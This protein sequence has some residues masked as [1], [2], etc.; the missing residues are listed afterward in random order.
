[1]PPFLLNVAAVLAVPIALL[2]DRAYPSIL[3]ICIPHHNM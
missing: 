1:M 3:A 2:I